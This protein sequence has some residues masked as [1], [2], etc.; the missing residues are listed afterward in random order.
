MH[1]CATLAFILCFAAGPSLAEHGNPFSTNKY[2][3][4][5]LTDDKLMQQPDHVRPRC[6]LTGDCGEPLQRKPTCVENGKCY[7]ALAAPGQHSLFPDP[8]SQ[9]P[10]TSPPGIPSVPLPAT[11]ILLLGSLFLA[12]IFSSRPRSR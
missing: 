11:A 3:G 7:H 12:L 9:L 1:M 5:S 4:G 6:A 2:I 8:P 10:P